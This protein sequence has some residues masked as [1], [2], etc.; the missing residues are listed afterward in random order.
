M[1][2]WYTKHRVVCYL[3]NETINASSSKTPKEKCIGVYAQLS[4]R[5]WHMCGDS[6]ACG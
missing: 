4:S 5:V 2:S 6:D 3:A 1:V